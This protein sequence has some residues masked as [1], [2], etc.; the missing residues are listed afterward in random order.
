MP[1][2]VT[3]RSL[4]EI[5][6]R[7][8]KAYS[9]A[10][11]LIANISVEIPYQI[12][13]GVLVWASWYFPIFGDDQSS[14]R[15]GLMLLFCI[16][17]F[18]YSSTFAHMVIAALPDAETAGNIATFLFS[19]GL[20]F[21]GVLQTPD[22]LPGF[23]LFMYRVS[24]FTYL[25]SGWA[26]T[27]LAG[28]RIE[29]AENELAQFNPPSGQTC[30]QYLADYVS[31]GAP[32]QLLNPDATSNCSYCPLSTSDQFLA[33]VSISYETRWRDFGI[34]WGYIA[35][36]V[37]MAVLLYYAFRVK[38]WSPKSIKKG[39]AVLAERVKR[40]CRKMFTGHAEP[41]PRGKEGVNHKVY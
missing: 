41:T 21:N 29:C 28:R 40:A 30:A 24:P 18:I 4:Y 36:N 9:A 32:G 1:R 12:L 10:A 37:V 34:G 17:F 26:G 2:F 23:W 25:V 20:T 5:R 19:M 31:S 15:K 16:Q 13:L 33:G 22:A 14:D 38:N 27:G 3:Q 7:P 39:P 11:F 6:E 8:S 35:F